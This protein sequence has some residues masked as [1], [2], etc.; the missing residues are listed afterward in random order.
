MLAPEHVRNA[1]VYRMLKG[2]FE[3]V[4]ALPLTPDAWI[5]DGGYAH[6][7][8][9][10]FVSEIGPS[11]PF[12]VI[13][14]RGFSSTKYNPARAIGAP[15]EHCHT[16]RWPM[17]SGMAWDADYWR[18]VSQRA[19]LGEL[20][21]PG[22][23]SLFAGAHREYA[24]HLCREKLKEMVQTETRTLYVWAEAP[25]RHD[26]SDSHAMCYAGAA[27]HAG[28]GPG[29]GPIRRRRRKFTQEDLLRRR[30]ASTK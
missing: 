30:D 17:G 18:M 21:E 28:I 6:N 14:A 3:A 20:G 9:Q 19:W 24:E 13:V 10:R 12:R 25:G 22:S 7:V 15:R 8:V 4:R 27:Y 2:H 5:I 1:I 26:W 23:C 11:L 29:G 16:A